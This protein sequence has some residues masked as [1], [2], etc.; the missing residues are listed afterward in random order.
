MNKPLVYSALILGLIA[1]APK[2]QETKVWKAQTSG[3]Q[4]RFRGVWA[5]NNQTVWAS[6]S[7]G[8]CVKTTDG[9]RHW[10]T[11]TVP[12]AS[13]LDFR[14]VQAFDDRNALLL[15]AGPGKSGRIYQ[16]QDG[17]SSWKLVFINPDETG[18]LDAFAFWNQREGI[19]LGDPINERFS[20]FQ[21][22]DGGAT[23]T[24]LEPESL[25]KTLVNEGAFAASG[26]CIAVQGQNQVWFASG[27]SGRARIY[28]SVDRGRNWTVHD[29]PIRADNPSSGV[30]SLTF[31]DSKRGVAVGGDY[32][33]ADLKG[34]N[35]AYTNDGGV[36]WTLADNH[37]QVGYR[38]AVAVISDQHLITVG[39]QGADVSKDGGRHWTSFSSQGFHAVATAN[40]AVWAVGEMGFIAQSMGVP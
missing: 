25:P 30:F 9:G 21:T 2:L 35:V 7:Q 37:D 19:A 26:T 16:T 15:A 11:S 20:L 4:A 32:Q 34:K 28:R 40:Q 3:T 33:K 23:W 5:V 24:R 1:S 14:D 31:L 10:T 39:P 18:F 17:G 6:G 12:G 29:A 38:S 36:T 22:K 8:T 13:L 27:G